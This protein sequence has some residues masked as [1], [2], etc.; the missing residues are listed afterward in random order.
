MRIAVY[1]IARDEEQF[2]ERFCLSAKEADLIIIGDTGSGDQTASLAAAC[3]ATVYPVNVMPWR[4]D[5]AR[6]TVLSLIPRDI[7]VCVSMDLDEVLVEGWRAVVEAAWKPGTTRMRYGFDWGKGVAFQA[8]KIHSRTG[9]HWHHPCHESIRPDPRLTESWTSTDKT[10]VL[11]LPDDTKSR[12]QYLH[13]LEVGAKEDPHCSRNAIYYGRELTFTGLWDK[14]ITEL[15]R[16]LQ[17]PSSTWDAER[18][19]AMRLIG[20]GMEVLGRPEEALYWYRQATF[21][22]PQWREPFYHLGK[23][24]YRRALWREALTAVQASLGIT[25]R[26]LSYLAEPEAWGAGPW[27][28][29]AICLYNLGRYEDARSHGQTALT[30]APEDARLAENCRQY[31]AMLFKSSKHDTLSSQ[32]IPLP[33][34]VDL[35]ISRA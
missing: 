22:A 32:A 20:D 21:E 17:L 35:E 5:H 11:H 18:A 27:D 23:A 13:L 10:L 6:N 2:V 1:A 25:V 31:D 19:Y 3:G 14:A 34:A 16:Y 26:P 15:Q 29:A 4:F 7:D 30:H 12:G 8:E 9:Y 33:S 28:V 24:L